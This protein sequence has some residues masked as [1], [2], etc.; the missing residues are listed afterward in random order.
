M[1]ISLRQILRIDKIGKEVIGVANEKL[2]NI[3]IRKAMLDANISQGELAE[4]LEMSEPALSI[5]LRYE[6]AVKVQNEIV[7]KI[8][9]TRR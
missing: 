9:D 3:K 8:R 5:M 2:A 7:A 1:R 6:L 4:I